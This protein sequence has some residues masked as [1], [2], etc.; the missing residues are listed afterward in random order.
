MKNIIVTTTS[1]FL[2]FVSCVQSF[3]IYPQRVILQREHYQQFQST[4]YRNV[5]SHFRRGEVRM[6][7]QRGKRLKKEMKEEK[8]KDV[9]A[10]IQ[11]P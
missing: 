7:G 8:K 2:I 3:T 6:M 11:T 9:P 4:K 5:P 10:R 1:I